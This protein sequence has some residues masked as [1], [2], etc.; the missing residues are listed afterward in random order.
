MSSRIRRVLAAMIVVA[1]LGGCSH[2]GG[3]SI[4]DDSRTVPPLPQIPA[5]Q[6]RDLVS[7]PWEV[8]G[9]APAGR[10]FFIEVLG[11]GCFGFRGT[12]TAV[13]ATDETM[14]LL[15]SPVRCTAS[16]IGGRIILA[17]EL[18]EPLG[19]RQLRHAPAAV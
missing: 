4:P 13:T 12:S 3:L 9:S 5:A 7:V 16:G 15:A 10:A 11:P 6:A 17:V 2:G 19:T 8:S 14:A 1:A 18:P